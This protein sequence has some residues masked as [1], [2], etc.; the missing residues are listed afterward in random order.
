MSGPLNLEQLIY[1]LLETPMFGD[2]DESGLAQIVHIMQVQKVRAGQLL[3]RE[4]QPGDAW[5]VVY[6]G[7]VEVFKDDVDGERVVATLGP[8]SCVGE[9]ALLDG[10]SRSASVRVTAPTTVLR[11]PRA[12]FAKLLQSEN[13]AAY[14]LVHQMALVLVARQRQTTSRL[15]QLLA[16]NQSRLLREGIAPIVDEH[17][18]TE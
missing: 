12:E 15:A 3:F 14:K 1:F 7:G 11:F 16:A 8:R 17:A 2:L 4:G 5:Y 13:L 6:E 9:M 18:M 10:S